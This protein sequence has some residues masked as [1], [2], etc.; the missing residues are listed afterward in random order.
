MQKASF[1]L[2]MNSKL[3]LIALYVLLAP[4][5]V[6]GQLIDSS[7][8]LT[9]RGFRNVRVY[10]IYKDS[11]GFIWMGTND[12][13]ARF[14]GYSLDVYHA[15]VTDSNALQNDKIGWIEGDDH[16]YLWAGTEDGLYRMHL[17][18]PG[19]F[20][21]VQLPFPPN[22]PVNTIRVLGIHRDSNGM[23]WIC[24]NYHGFYRLDP[25]TL[26][27][28][29][30]LPSDYFPELRSSL[31]LNGVR[32]ASVDL[33]DDQ[34]VWLGGV[35]GLFEMDQ[36][37]DSL[38]LHTMDVHYGSGD[39]ARS[40]FCQVKMD[41][42]I[43]WCGT[44]SA[45][46]VKYNPLS[47]EFEQ[48]IFHVDETRDQGALNVVVDMLYE[49]PDRLWVA[50]RDKGFGLFDLNT[51]EFHFFQKPFKRDYRGHS[52]IMDDHGF[53]WSGHWGGLQVWEIDNSRKP[54]RPAKV[55]VREVLDGDDP[56][57]WEDQ[58]L[59][60]DRGK[61]NL[62]FTLT[63]FNYYP[64]TQS[65]FAYM[66]D[67]HDHSWQSST[68]N[69]VY[70]SNIKGGQYTFR[71]KA[72][73]N[74]G[75][76]SDET[77]VEVSIPVLLWNRPWFIPAA[78]AF[79]LLIIFGIYLWQLRRKRA[80]ERL[81]HAFEKVLAEVEMK[82]LR[83]QMNPHFLFNSLNSIN[84][85]ILKSDQRSASEYLTKFS[86]LMRLI[87]QNSKEKTVSLAKELEALE[88]YVELEAQRLSGRF[89]YRFDVQDDID[90]KQI[91]IPPLILQPYVENAIWHGLMNKE[92]QGHLNVIVKKTDEQIV[93][94]IEDDGIGREKAMAI[95]SK[96]S[97][98][99]ESMGLQITNHR[100]DLAKKLLNIDSKVIISD[101]ESHNGE[102][103]GTRVEV[104][105]PIT[106]NQLT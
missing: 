58:E 99:K 106:E 94:I 1:V 70:L 69:H 36:S 67:G 83:A 54:D 50:S 26:E 7:N 80:K 39:D 68:D 47:R 78:T 85:F 74:G 41:N 22:I 88:L 64:N 9:E 102:P 79:I 18:T 76:W 66:L 38:T 63:D 100:I 60:L 105:I 62:E 51:E 86:W 14:D 8:V 90:L 55:L 98:K 71:A 43:I 25:A 73:W 46:L 77:V 92:G 53:L 61:H 19:Y 5:T 87:L 30:F 97:K 95:R 29:N 6:P 48:F 34:K 23:L 103:L 49:K 44:W 31:R 37:T 27:T 56:L 40:V 82:A 104:V 4:L 2:H 21:R 89:S 28:R 52:V 72:R 12:G 75:P 42:G 32:Q 93:C 33:T 13:L 35:G 3:I 57:V 17:D 45:G 59:H 81:Q 65:E 96:S 24:T 10:S 15:D 101:L 84:N 11:T 91:R 16:G 20:H